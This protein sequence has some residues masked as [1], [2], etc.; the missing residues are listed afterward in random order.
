LK[1]NSSR[2]AIVSACC[3]LREFRGVREELLDKA[4]HGAGQVHEQRRKRQLIQRLTRP[5]RIVASGQHRI[6]KRQP[7]AIVQPL[8][9]MG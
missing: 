5:V 3:C 6:A 4:R 7:P 1:R 8:Q 2:S 9:A